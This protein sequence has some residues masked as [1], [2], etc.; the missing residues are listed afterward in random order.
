V[1]STA[2]LFDG[3]Q[4][5]AFLS[6]LAVGFVSLL[7]VTGHLVDASPAFLFTIIGSLLHVGWQVSTVDLNSPA[8]C[9]SK[10]YSNSWIGFVMLPGFILNYSQKL[11]TH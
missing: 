3:W 5:K 10:F 2:I 11:A 8:D 9:F 4:A 6:V 7:A 1:K